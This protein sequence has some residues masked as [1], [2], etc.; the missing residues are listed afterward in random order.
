MP[1]THFYAIVGDM[2]VRGRRAPAP[3]TIDQFAGQRITVVAPPS[4]PAQVNTIL[5]GTVSGSIA[6]IVQVLGPQEWIVQ[7]LPGQY[8]VPGLAFGQHYNLAGFP[9]TGE[10]ITLDTGGSAVV[11]PLLAAGQSQPGI[12]QFAT[13]HSD[14]WLS[15]FVPADQSDTVWLDW[16]AKR[17]QTVDVSGVTGT[18]SIGDRV[19]T[20][21]G[22]SFTILHKPTATTWAIMRKEGAA[23]AAAQTL[24]N[25]TNP[26][27]A[28]TIAAVS[29]D[30]ARGT[31]CAYTVMPNGTGINPSGTIGPVDGVNGN[32]PDWEFPR[33]GNGTDGR[34]A[35]VGPENRLIH[36]AHAFWQLQPD[37]D[38]RATR[39]LTVSSMDDNEVDG[40]LGG[41]AIQVVRCTGAF[42][43]GWVPGEVVTGP[44]GWSAT[45][46]GHSVANKMVFVVATNGAVLGAGTITGAT[47]GATA[48]ADGAAHG[49][50]PGS[51]HFNGLVQ[52]VVAA[53]SAPGALWLNG[54][55]VPSAPNWEGIALM[56]WDSELL[57]HS[58]GCPPVASEVAQQQWVRFLEALRAIASRPDLPI[59]V[60]K[61]RI[62]SR[63]S[64]QL[65]G[66]PA[67]QFLHTTI[68]ALP[69]LLPRVVVVD[70]AAYEMAAP[71]PGVSAD[72]HLWLTTDSY[73][74]LGDDLWRALSFGNTDVEPGD[75]RRVPIVFVLGADQAT[76]FLSAQRAM[77]LDLDPDLWPSTTFPVGVGVDTT[78]PRCMSWNTRTLELQ[79]LHAGANA[80]GFWGTD[81]LTCGFELP[82]MSRF[83]M[84]VSADPDESDRCVL[85]KFAVPG[86]A[87]N[88]AVPNAT[89]TWDPDLSTR[90][91]L[92]VTVAVTAL[93]ATSSLPARGRLT[94]AAGT[95]TADVW[96]VGLSVVIRGSA[97]GVLGVGGNNTAPY[98]V[99]TVRD[100]AGDGSWI[101][102]VGPF[103]A[104]PVAN[105]TLTAGPPPLWPELRRQI[106]ALFQACAANRMI[107]DP[108]LV[109]VEQGEQDLA[110]VD[111]YEAALRRFWAALEPLLGMRGKGESA[112]A[113]CVVLT[114]EKTPVAVPDDD[115]RQLREI[116]AR[117]GTELANSVV[118]D[119][120]KLPMEYGG[121]SRRTTRLQNGLRFSGRG[122]VTKGFM[123]DAA[124]GTLGPSK[125]IPEH[126]KGELDGAFFGAVNGGSDGL[127]APTALTFI[128]GATALALGAP[129]TGGLVVEDGTG[130]DNAESLCSVE[131]FTA[132]WAQNN[133][134]AAVSGATPVQIAAALRRAT[135]EWVVGV[136]RDQW[137]GQIQYL[138][139]RLPFPRVGC[140]D[141][142]GRQVA[143]G[144]I[145]WQ[146]VHATCLVAGHLLEGGSVLANGADQGPITRETKKGAGFEKTV[147]Y[148]APVNGGAGGV[149][150][151]RAAEALVATFM[152]GSTGGQVGRS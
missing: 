80:N 43:G 123:V 94:A 10:T 136:C 139:Q 6:R 11:A 3:L 84:R 29:A 104:E 7:S 87:L 96:T 116:Q 54:S 138:N 79:P 85:A 100:R 66:V 114:T 5:R 88:A 121:F 13:Q 63:Q 101:E 67:S 15:D 32:D 59:A 55:S 34:E 119:P 99:A 72:P 61:H 151:L 129:A 68:D 115:V 135:R 131:E 130:V 38:D 20:S 53:L 23:L 137:R 31:W 24:T 78:D 106:D 127:T 36:R 37:V 152:R 148:A 142:D 64:V 26:G 103:V 45:V 35:S 49:W 62:E 2:H 40:L 144:T 132:F 133:A 12:N 48:T 125:G 56:V 76:G 17:A 141:D 41:V 143:Q 52:R 117:V 108:R 22:G 118:V 30:P 110:L 126:P 102:V 60:W 95:F 77:E 16:N 120:S 93:A 8:G 18:W 71:Q 91:E 27:G 86:S 122:M 111:E 90:P 89:A 70:S 9:N 39:F 145:P 113:K 149:T 98:R 42:A 140:S 124:I 58:F 25:L 69:S 47:S 1:H 46:H 107:P 57:V 4:P 14:S 128:G 146:V 74:H 44:G 92:A 75:W 83:K 109:I 19:Q 105:L 50:Q 51:T 21:A 28:A 147:E 82:I 81:P 150:R 97:L 134:S 73:V 65:F 33:N 112:I